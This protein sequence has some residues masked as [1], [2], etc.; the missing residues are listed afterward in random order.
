MR[1]DDGTL[2]YV[3]EN[4]ANMGTLS[5]ETYARVV[6]Y[7]ELSAWAARCSIGRMAH[8]LYTSGVLSTGD[9]VADAAIH[10][11]RRQDR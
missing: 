3:Y 10:T 6:T 4:G 9:L 8:V 5:N 11:V 2:L 7:C 1:V